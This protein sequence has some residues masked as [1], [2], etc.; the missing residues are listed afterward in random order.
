MADR[1]AKGSRVVLSRAIHPEYREVVQTYLRHL[2][3][4]IQEVGWGEDGRTDPDR[5]AEILAGEPGRVLCVAVQQPNFFGCTE[6]LDALLGLVGE[7]APEA[8][9]IVSV[10]EPYALGL[11]QPPG[12]Q[13]ADVVCGEMQ[14]FGS[15][16]NY[17][18]PY[19]G[20]FATGG[21]HVRNL[22]GRLVGRT[23]DA[24]GEEG[25]VLTLSTREQHI[26]REKATS[27]I[28]TNEG[29]VALAASIHLSLL[30]AG[31]VEEAARM[32]LDMAW[33]AMERV[34]EVEGFTRRF[35]A[36]FFNEFTVRSGREVEP[37]LWDLMEKEILAGV[38][39]GR[40]YPELEDCWLMACTELTRREDVERLRSALEEVSS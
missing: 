18:G 33:H 6:D 21:R 15:P 5:L 28:C 31:G 2:D 10:T 36:P 7:K 3:L 16:P 8:V 9:R 22:P 4:E 17:G 14:A 24:D 37:L 29:L 40:W 34:T 39:L 26:R 38:P 13:G 27:N 11:L 12:R 35:A 25:Y 30:G 1:S 20:F 19:L 23:V 32:S